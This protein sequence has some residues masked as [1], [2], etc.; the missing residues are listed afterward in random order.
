MK[1]TKTSVKKKKKLSAEDVRV[2]YLILRLNSKCTPSFIFPF[3]GEFVEKNQ[4]REEI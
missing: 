3:Y 1:I 4:R 2:N